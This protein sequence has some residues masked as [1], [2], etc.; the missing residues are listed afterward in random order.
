MGLPGVDP[1]TAVLVNDIV[2]D[3]H[4]AQRLPEENPAGGIK[5]HHVVVNFHVAHRGIAGDLQA[6]GRIADQHVIEHDLVVAAQ[7]QSMIQIAARAS[8]VVNVVGFVAVIV[9]TLVGI[10][11]VF[12]VGAGTGG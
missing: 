1:V 7:I 8:V 9:G 10:G 6:S 3:I 12:A 2:L 5:R 4:S 11:T